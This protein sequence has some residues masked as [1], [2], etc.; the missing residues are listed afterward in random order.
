ML[1]ISKLK[2][3]RVIELDDSD[4]IW[5]DALLRTAKSHIKIEWA[6]SSRGFFYYRPSGLWKQTSRS[7]SLL[8][9]RESVQRTVPIVEYSY[10]CLKLV[11]EIA[12]NKHVAVLTTG[13]RPSHKTNWRSSRIVNWIR[14]AYAPV[15]L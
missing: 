5:A 10:D 13:P 1:V 11:Y 14:S 15:R 3:E 12:D 9:R 7:F 2:D 8:L 6:F 4:F